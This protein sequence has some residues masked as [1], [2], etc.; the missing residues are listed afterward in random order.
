[1]PDSGRTRSCASRA[2]RVSRCSGTRCSAR[3]AGLRHR[4][5]C[6]RSASRSGGISR[7]A[8]SAFSTITL[9]ALETL[10]RSALIALL[11]IVV[12][13]H[14]RRAWSIP[15]Q[16]SLQGGS[17][18]AIGLGAVIAVFSLVGFES[19]TSL[20][21]EAQGAASRTIPLGGNLERHHLGHVLRRLRSTRRS[22]G[23]RGFH[24][25]LDKLTTPLDTLSDIMRVPWLKIPIDIGALFSSFSVALGEPSMRARASSTRWAAAACSPTTSAARTTSTSHRTSRCRCSPSSTS[26]SRCC[27]S[28]SST[29]RRPTR[30]AIPRRWA[31]SGSSR[32]TFRSPSA[33][34]STSAVS[35]R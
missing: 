24:T 28:S 5:C 18:S 7:S 16:L 3:S 10:R 9:L 30:S 1:M 11:L 8:T 21:E 29:G 13:A 4:S 26:S 20:G 27:C 25:T 15:D 34:R 19:A 6:R 12:F 32:S 2:S 31:R 23:T 35:A 33:A 22:S 17:L 14:M